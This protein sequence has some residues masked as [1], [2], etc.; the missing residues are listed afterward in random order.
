MKSSQANISESAQ[1]THLKNKK[2][3]KQIK[4]LIKI[5]NELNQ[6]IYICVQDRKAGTVHHFSSD[7]VN[8]GNFHIAK[9]TKDVAIKKIE[10]FNAHVSKMQD[11]T[12][13][14]DTKDS[15][16]SKKDT[17]A[18]TQ[19]PKSEFSKITH[20]ENQEGSDIEQKL[21]EADLSNVNFEI[22][23]QKSHFE[24]GD[25]K[26]SHLLQPDML[27]QMDIA[28]EMSYPGV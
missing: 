12:F 3:A 21:S 8:F 15:A 14:D 6:D 9:A 19:G 18:S 4:Q 16:S 28:N 13:V 11:Q 22:F 24:F 23:D 17:E 10:H 25:H 20:F 2:R 5:M 27:S 7:I 26:L 1:Q